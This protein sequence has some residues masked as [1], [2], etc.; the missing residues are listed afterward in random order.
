MNLLEA[1]NI[2]EFQNNVNVGDSFW[3]CGAST[4]GKNSRFA[5]NVKPCLV[6]VLTKTNYGNAETPRWNLTWDLSKAPQLLKR[7]RF[8][9][10][11][12][13]Y[14]LTVEEEECVNLY[15]ARITE[16][17]SRCGSYARKQKMLL[18]CMA[19]HPGED[20]LANDARTWQDT[21]TDL[22]RT[23]IEKLIEIQT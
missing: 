16:L 4:E 23:Y 21:L 22:E 12:W 10:M 5:M 20:T 13:S 11:G 9:V 1:R 17:A 18:S 19:T 7:R 15:D 8:N 3:F 2:V 14:I 6:T